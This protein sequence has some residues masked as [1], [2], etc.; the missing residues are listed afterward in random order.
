AL[1]VGGGLSGFQFVLASEQ[2]NVTNV[3][4]GLESKGRGFE[5]S[6][7][8]MEKLNAAFGTSVTLVS[9]ALPHDSVP[10]ESFDRVFCISAIEHFAE[11]EI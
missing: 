9:G 5:C 10:P 8:S 2:I 4:P 3:D 11:E 1:E 7:A 6:P